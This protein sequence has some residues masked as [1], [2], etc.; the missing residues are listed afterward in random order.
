[1][2]SR[3]RTRLTATQSL[4]LGVFVIILIGAVLLKLPISNKEGQSIKFID[5]LFTSTSCVCVTGL[6]TIVPSE[7]FSTFGQIVLM[8][9]IEIG[10]LGFM[11]FI[12]LI[13]IFMGKK[14]NLSDRIVIKESLNQNNMSG[15]IQL[16]KKIFCYT[17][18]FQTIGAILLSI[19]FIPTYGV[20]KGIYYSIFHSISA[21]CNAGFDILG[22]KSFI[23]YQYDVLINIT[24]MALIILGGLGFT[25]WDD[26]FN[27]IKEKIKKK[28]KI[29]R[30]WTELSIHTK[31]VLVTTII[32]LISGTVLTFVFEKD[33]VHIMKNDTLDQKILKSS[34]YS[35]T[36]RT[37]GITTI[38]VNN[39][40][41][42]T[43]FI[44]AM[45]MFIGASPAST[46]G[47]IKNVTFAIIILMAIS[48]IKDTDSTVVFK[49]EI[50][51]KVIK[52]AISVV[53]L[54]ICVV[55]VSIILL[56]ITE[57]L[58]LEQKY[59]MV[60]ENVDFM[61]I[62]YEVFSAFGTVGLTLGIT[63]KLSIVGKVIIMILMFI[64][65]VGTITLSFALFS[66]YNKNKKSTIKYPKCDLLVG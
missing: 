54:S 33:N 65:R 45:Y 66:K 5:S 24:L 53:T 38:D 31:L 4:V 27:S 40:T 37:A 43:K 29:N 34:F 57:Q 47:G 51:L 18:T 1:M 44:S 3:K 23:P 58:F 15:L 59:S 11:S 14:I 64:G 28:G 2:E 39:L 52:R 8:C 26:L 10:G 63:P 19:K 61:G 32:L 22:D 17:I 55:I 36:L 7:Q 42:T 9:L 49:R 20:G 62:I 48:F 6:N 30:I 21:F 50:P 35:T 25:V 60:S 16:I 41:T 46:A 12:A 13:L 56:T